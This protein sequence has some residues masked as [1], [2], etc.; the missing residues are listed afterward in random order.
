MDFIDSYSDDEESHDLNSDGYDLDIS[1]AKAEYNY[2]MAGTEVPE[3]PDQISVEKYQNLIL[4]DVVHQKIMEVLSETNLS[5]K[6]ADF[7]LISLHVLGNK[8]NLILVSP[9]GSGKM[10]GKKII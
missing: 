9:T 4:N 5:F 8:R 1:E 7:Q 2:N 6:L 10:L 3:P